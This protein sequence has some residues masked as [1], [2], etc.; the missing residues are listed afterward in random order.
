MAG[1]AYAHSAEGQAWLGQGQQL[2]DA[3]AQQA[4]HAQQQAAQQAMEASE[5][6]TQ[7]GPVMRM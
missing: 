7:R 6:Q 1:R 2:N 4:E 5:A 3:L